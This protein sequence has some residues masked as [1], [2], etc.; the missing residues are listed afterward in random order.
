MSSDQTMKI[1]I[2]KDRGAGISI[3]LS[4]H[5]FEGSIAVHTC[6]GKLTSIERDWGC[7]LRSVASKVSAETSAFPVRPVWTV[8]HFCACHARTQCAPE[9]EHNHDRKHS[10]HR[11]RTS[12][13]KTRAGIGS[14]ASPS[15]GALVHSTIRLR[16]L[17]LNAVTRSPSSC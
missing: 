7:R 8:I 3:S 2:V 15:F 16:S 4:P 14:T 6:D 10:A 13:P 12:R 11:R 5:C 9:L 17:R 1:T